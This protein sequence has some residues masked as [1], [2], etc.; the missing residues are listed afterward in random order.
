VRNDARA[1]FQPQQPRAHHQV[2][3]RQ[4]VDRDDRCLVQVRLVEVTLV[5][6]GAVGNTCLGR[7]AIGELH[8]P[9]VEID[10][11]PACAVLLSS[12]DDHAPVAGAKVD[13]VIA[14]T[15]VRELQHRVDDVLR[16]DDVRRIAE[17][18]CRARRRKPDEQERHNKKNLHGT[19]ACRLTQHAS[20][21]Q[22]R[23]APH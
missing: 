2:H 19:R 9:P 13:H 6:H 11:K 7:I 5:K 20:G 21:Y 22:L 1:G 3:F 4:Q 23:L 12:G 17:I 14:R 16:R 18:L 15:D 8:E 10:P